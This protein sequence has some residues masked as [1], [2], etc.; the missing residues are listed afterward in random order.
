MAAVTAEAPARRSLTW[1]TRQRTRRIAAGMPTEN[2]SRTTDGSA[3]N[4]PAGGAS[5]A[6]L[7]FVSVVPPRFAAS[8]AAV[9]RHLRNGI[10]GSV[11][12]EPLFVGYRTTSPSPTSTPDRASFY[13]YERFLATLLFLA[14]ILACGLMPM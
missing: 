6:N 13:T 3:V 4:S 2:N 12:S 7:S 10:D 14:I 1:A 11:I 9:R 8:H 5:I